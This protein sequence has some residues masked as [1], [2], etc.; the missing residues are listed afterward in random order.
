M[1]GITSPSTGSNA[2]MKYFYAWQLRR[3]YAR[4]PRSIK[5]EFN[6]MIGQWGTAGIPVSE[7]SFR[8][9]REAKERGL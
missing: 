1:V 4:L 3:L 8:L 2:M 9:R 5:N 6:R 7:I